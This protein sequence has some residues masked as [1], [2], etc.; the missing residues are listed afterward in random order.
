MAVV[1]KSFYHHVP[2]DFSANIDKHI[3]VMDWI[4][5]LWYMSQKKQWNF[6]QKRNKQTKKQ[7]KNKQKQKIILNPARWQHTGGSGES[8][9][10]PK[11]DRGATRQHP[12]NFQTERGEIIRPPSRGE[13]S[14]AEKSAIV[15]SA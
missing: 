9:P 2:K 7:L 3:S 13:L 8:C 12:R 14:L 4:I 10:A 11:P 15:V 6:K 1:D 5:N